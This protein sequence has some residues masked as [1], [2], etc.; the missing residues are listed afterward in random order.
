MAKRDVAPSGLFLSI[1]DFFPGP[2][3]GYQLSEDG[4]SLIKK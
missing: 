2:G 1:V 4:L 3:Q